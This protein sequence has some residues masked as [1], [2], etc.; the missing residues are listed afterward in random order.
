[1]NPDVIKKAQKNLK[2]LLIPASLVYGI[3]LNVRDLYYSKKTKKQYN[4]VKIISVGNI[5]VG[6]VGKTPLVIE[7]ARFLKDYGKVCV[8][9][10]NYPL[11]DKGVHVVSLDGSIFKKPPKVP[12]E[13]Y[14]IA[15]K[16][17]VSVI[18]SKIREAAIE[19]AI[20]FKS[21]FII[22]DDALHKKHIKK[23]LEICVVDKYRP[24]DNGLYLPA[25]MLR[26]TK[27]SLKSCNLIVCVDKDMGNK[28]PT[29]RGTNCIDV[30][31]VIN[32]VYDKNGRV[33]IDRKS[34]IAFCGIGNP[35]SFKKTLE[36]LGIYIKAFFAFND[37]HFYTQNDIDF[38]KKE[39][40]KKKAD[41]L[42][43]TYKDFVKL[44]NEKDICY[45]DISL[46]I[47][48]IKEKLLKITN[49]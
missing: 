36:S 33:E 14:M 13:P 16:V 17:D 34:V 30:K 37:H 18:A 7:I 28:K 21:K 42:L 1:M 26:D 19:L 2:P 9:T 40:E 46:N 6:G 31:M 12:D 44:E 22:L 47:E 49:E 43:T 8:I 45:V 38:L 20:G 11:K 15:K 25:G 48:N 29:K 10:N 35:T 23:D 24:F 5:V 32:G 3:I 39:K 27:K 41:L 4:G